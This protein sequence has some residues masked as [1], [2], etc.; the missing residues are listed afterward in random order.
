MSSL[1]LTDIRSCQRC[2]QDLPLPP[3][4]IIQ[5]ST[6][7]RIQIIGQAPGLATH[8]FNRPFKDKSGDR[9][10]DWLAISEQDFYNPSLLAI[11]PM[12]HFVIRV[13]INLAVVTPRHQKDAIALGIMHLIMHLPQYNYVS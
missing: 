7:A 11:T 4:P 8:K 6:Q 9:L 5:F 10:R 1:L 2:K 3:N 13:R 12:G